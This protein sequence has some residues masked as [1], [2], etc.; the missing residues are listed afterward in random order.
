ML[1]QRDG[2][3]DSRCA[4]MRG[5]GFICSTWDDFGRVLFVPQTFVLS[6][7]TMLLSFRTSSHE[8]S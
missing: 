1:A 7:G 4:Q 8:G 3:V 6:A 5:T 2:R